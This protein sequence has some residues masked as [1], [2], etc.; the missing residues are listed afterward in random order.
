MKRNN[1]YEKGGFI[2]TTH[3]GRPPRFTTLRIPTDGVDQVPALLMQ[4]ELVIPKKH[5][6]MVVHFLR[7]HNINLPNTK[8]IK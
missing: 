8:N 4:G 1:L 2:E 5:V 3:L 6:S 7:H